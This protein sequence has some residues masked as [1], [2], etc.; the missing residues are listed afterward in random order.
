MFL[1]VLFSYELI[2]NTNIIQNSND[3]ISYRSTINEHNTN[4]NA[5][6]NTNSSRRRRRRRG[7]LL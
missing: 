6:S 4:N 2:L 7:I 5:N 3:L 1:L